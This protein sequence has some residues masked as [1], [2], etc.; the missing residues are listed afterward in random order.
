VRSNKAYVHQHFVGH[1][2]VGSMVVVEEQELDKVEEQ[3]LVEELVEELDKVEEQELVEEL[4]EE[5]D[6][7]RELA[8]VQELVVEQEQ[9]QG[10]GLVEELEQLLV[11]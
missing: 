11:H 6:K 4:V 3:E 10:Q 2:L 5:L 8:V 1:N 9:E 7:E